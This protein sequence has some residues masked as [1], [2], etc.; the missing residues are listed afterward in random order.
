[1]SDNC[2]KFYEL[3]VSSDLNTHLALSLLHLSII[4]F[5]TLPLPR[6]FQK[7]SSRISFRS[8]KQT[9][10]FEIIQEIVTEI[11]FFYFNK[12]NSQKFYVI[13]VNIDLSIR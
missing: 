10:K 6:I 9:R 8:K 2:T 7:F 5:G 11:I 12:S 13:K 1:M 4:S 3:I